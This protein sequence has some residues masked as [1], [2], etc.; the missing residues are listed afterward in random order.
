MHDELAGYRLE[1]LLGR[2]G[3]GE[4][5]LAWDEGPVARPVAVKRLGASAGP[6][7]AESLRAE[8]ELLATLDHPH[9]L[10]VIEVVDD[11]PGLALVLPYLSGGSLRDLLDDH[12]ALSPGEVVALLAP[13]ADAAGSLHRRGLVHGDLKPDNVL[14]TSDGAPVLADVG[15]A[16]IIGRPA[17]GLAVAGTPAY[18]DPATA[19]GS[20]PGAGADVY[21]LGVVAYEALTGRLPHLGEPAEV[22]ALAAARVHRPL[23][24]WPA[25]PAAVARL[26][27]QAL[28]PDPAAR[29]AG[30]VAF[31]DALSAVVPASEIRLP[32]GVR[33]SARAEPGPGGRSETIRFGPVPPRVD[34]ASTTGRRS[35]GARTLGAVGVVAVALVVAAGLSTGGRRSDPTTRPAPDARPASSSDPARGEVGPQPDAGPPAS[36]AAG[37]AEPIAPGG[38]GPIQRGDIDADGCAEALRWDGSVLRVA[39]T[40]GTRTY[41]IGSPS[42]QVLFGDWD[43]DGADSPALYRPS[44]GE[45]LYVDR[46]PT[47]VGGQVA[48]TRLEQVGRHGIAVVARRHGGRD[49]VRVEDGP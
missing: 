23:A 28:D 22:V 11:P 48:A 47:R 16:R 36:G 40:A 27:E 33:R 38:T 12:G 14:L 4:V 34:P 2:G 20:P 21:A 49:V 37:C 35:V 24:S 5:W 15:V 44:V 26:V 46:F 17:I 3:T 43:G 8:A 9:L 10:R 19:D 13:V 6:A 39:T 32:A 29:P 25:V 30:T 1:R 45:V 7:E 42:D 31:V 41:R 18:L